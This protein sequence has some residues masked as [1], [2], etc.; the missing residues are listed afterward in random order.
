MDNPCGTVISRGMKFDT[1]I[2]I[3]GGGLNGPALALA[4][5]QTGVQV[6][7]IDAL[8]VKVRK[9]AGFDGRSY[10]L[11]LTSTR[12]LQ[13]IA[14]WDAVAP[15][16]QP[17]LEIKV[18]D[19]RA[20]DGPSPMFM[21][22]DHA[23]IEEGPMGFMVE[24]RHLRPA[25][26]DAVQSTPG[27]TQMH[28]QTVVNQ[29]VDA[30]GITLTLASGKTLRARLAVGAD[31]R[32]T[33]T[34][35]RAGIKR[36]GWEYGQ[37]ALVCAIEHEMPHHGVAHQFFMPPG[38]LAILPLTKNRSSIVWS[39]TAQ[40]AAAIHALSDEAYIDVLR[41]RFGSFLGELSLAGRRYTYPLSLSLAHNMVAS[42]V[43]LVGD[44]AHGV[45]PIAGQGLNAGLRDV[46]ALAEI[47]A[48]TLRRGEDIGSDAALA[49]YQE[50]RRF[51]NTSLALATD[52]F[53]R[54]FSNDNPLVRMARDIGMAAVNALPG[55]RRGFI[56]EAAG[57]TGDLPRIMQGKSL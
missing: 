40:N 47:I 34:G 36:I 27:I 29:Q 56:R 32:G 18:T 5:A 48:D 13:G 51:D 23:E 38:P 44:A 22:F 25:L 52:S 35:M 43:A 37:T 46:A 54:L 16:A 45:H 6:T 21:H 7:I 50:W 55:L 42:R 24:D 39:E 8:D 26:L 1:D 33:G 4:L 20:G 15:H 28:G 11:A 19:G 12:L 49:R 3:I 30:A 14:V 2:A 53:N 9:N 10:A 57:L 31:G 17:M 41:P